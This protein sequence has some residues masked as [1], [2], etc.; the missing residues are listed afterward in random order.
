MKPRFLF[1]T[2]GLVAALLAVSCAPSGATETVPPEPTASVAP[3]LAVET[4]VPPVEATIPAVL[5]VA[6]SRGPNL[7]ATDPT[8]VSLASGGLQLVEFFRFT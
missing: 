6:T 2:V 7:E 4:A 8:T 1:W 3:T 5:P